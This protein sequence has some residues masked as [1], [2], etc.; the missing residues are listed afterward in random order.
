MKHEAVAK[1]GDEIKG[2]DFIPTRT[3]PTF[4]QG[5]VLA[6]GHFDRGYYSY[7]VEVTKRFVNGID[8]TKKS[9]SIYFIPFE[10]DFDEFDTRVTLIK[11]APEFKNIACA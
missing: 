5:I 10:V 6:K 4:V 1:V 9:N 2:Y 11:K 3:N 7:K 8:V